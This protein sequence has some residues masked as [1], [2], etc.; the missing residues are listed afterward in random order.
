MEDMKPL[1]NTIDVKVNKIWISGAI[2]IVILLGVGF[3]YKTI[4]YRKVTLSAK[5]VGIAD[6]SASANN[7]PA[8]IIVDRPKDENKTVSVNLRATQVVS[9]LADG[10]TY[11]YW[12][13]NN[14]VPGPFIRVME[15]DTVEIS[16]THEHAHGGDQHSLNEPDH[17][18]AVSGFMPTVLANGNDGHMM[19]AEEMEHMEAGHGEHSIDL[20]AVIGPGGGAG[21]TRVAPN[22]TKTFQFK[23]TRPGIYVY[24]CASPHIPSHIANGMYGLILVEPKGGL[25]AADKEFYVVQGEVYTKGKVGEKGHQELDKDKLLAEKPEYIVFNGRVGAL[26][27]EGALQSNIGDKVRIFFG[28]SGQLAS[29]FHIIGEIFDKVYPEGDIVSPPHINVQTTLVPGGGAVMV[30]FT[31]EVPGKYL[32]VDHALTRAIDRG[33][34]GELIVSGPDIPGVIKA[35]Q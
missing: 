23:A 28:V 2:I 27:G 22:E 17:S 12:T 8:P 16:L 29:N 32:L 1:S 34:L 5:P 11:E 15:G 24:H 9:T 4:A 25:P 13:Y 31:A 3:L 33:A 21:L 6:I 30:E 7:L 10:T 20:H 35:I 14:Q 19:G 18:L 26:T